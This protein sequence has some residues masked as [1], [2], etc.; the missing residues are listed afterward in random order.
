MA[1]DPDSRETPDR[2]LNS[3]MDRLQGILDG[4]T[5]VELYAGRGRA[6]ARLLKEGAGQ[7]VAVDPDPPEDR[8][9]RDGLVWIRMD[10]LEFFDEPRVQKVGLVYSRPPF[11][12][13]LNRE[14]LER[15]PAAPN[16]QANCLVIL[17]E[18]AWNPTR[19]EDYPFLEPIDEI[20][21]DEAR[22]V[23]T[24]MVSPAAP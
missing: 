11:G 1:D 8:L 10:P 14:V 4:L 15:L 24:Q 20:R 5:A 7:A 17:E 13:G 6:S 18:P 19:V 16:L 23:L 3:L 2:A 22:V 21:V 12:E 9:E